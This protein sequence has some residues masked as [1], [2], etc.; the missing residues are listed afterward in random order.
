MPTLVSRLGDAVSVRVD[1]TGALETAAMLHLLAG[2]LSHA[3]LA[4]RKAQHELAEAELELLGR[5]RE[6]NLARTKKRA[7]AGR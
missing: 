2:R 6:E 4:L 3:A 7:M 5:V 1:N